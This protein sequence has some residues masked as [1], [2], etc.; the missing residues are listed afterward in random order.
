MKWTDRLMDSARLA[1]PDDIASSESRLNRADWIAAALELLIEVGIDAVRITT[2]ADAL[3][4]TRGSFYWHFKD[5]DDLCD[6]IIAHWERTNTAAVVSA[7]TGATS[8]DEGVLGLFDAW[9]DA[10]RFEPRL[11]SAM[12]DWARRSDT[13]HAAVE[14]ADTTRIAAIAELFSAHGFAPTDAFIRARIIYFAQVGYYALGIDETMV[15]R[16]GY[17]EAYYTG[18][19]GRSLDPEQAA[20]YRAKHLDGF[21]DV[22]S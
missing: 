6:A 19:T 9:L 16:F 13:V 12:R 7:V 1:R 2:L 22:Q 3:S 21:G 17:L 4:V 11:D 8:L 15:Q 10:T 14:E 5:R 18:F 20:A